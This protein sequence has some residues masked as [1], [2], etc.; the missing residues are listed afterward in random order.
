M[1]SLNEE[2][3][4]PVKMGKYDSEN[5]DYKKYQRLMNRLKKG[6]E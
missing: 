3:Y 6:N 2:L 1:D 5:P 4:I